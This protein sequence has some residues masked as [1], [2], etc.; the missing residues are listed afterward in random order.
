[1]GAY[2]EPS[3]RA[4]TSSRGSDR[5]SASPPMSLSRTVVAAGPRATEAA[6]FA[7][8]YRLAPASLEALAAGRG[9]CGSWSR[10]ARF[11]STCSPAWHSGERRAGRRSADAARVAL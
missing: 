5:Q 7:E 4:S 9:R 8:I 11:A 3:P 10:R 6:L 2:P 1:M